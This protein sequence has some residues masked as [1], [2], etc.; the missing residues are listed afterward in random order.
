M[1]DALMGLG[2]FLHGSGLFL[3]AVRRRGTNTFMREDLPPV[4]K[5]RGVLLCSGLKYV[6][7]SN[8]VVAS[9]RGLKRNC[10]RVLSSDGFLS[11]CSKAS[12][13]LLSLVRT[14]VSEAAMGGKLSVFEFRVRI[15]RSKQLCW[16]VS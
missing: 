1:A 7:G 2:P 5:N 14:A 13:W 12:V 15:T 9:G 11:E 3:A 10:N 6:L 4:L 8:L 16:V